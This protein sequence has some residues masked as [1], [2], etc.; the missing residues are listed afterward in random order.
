M[1]FAVFIII[2]VLSSYYIFKWQPKQQTK[3]PKQVSTRFQ[4]L[5][6]DAYDAIRTNKFLKAERA[7]LTILRFDEKNAG[8]YNRLGILYAKQKNY[9]DAIECFEIARS[10]E[11]SPS[12]L[13]NLGL[14][15][16]ETEDYHKSSEAFEAALHMEDTVA[17]RYIAYAKVQEKIDNMKNV[18]HA[19]ER[20]AIIEPS[21]QT[22]TLL[23]DAY[24]RNNQLEQSE[25]IL[26]KI[27]QAK[28]V[29]KKKLAPRMRQQPRRMVM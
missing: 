28:K 21:Q 9:D 18:V 25:T 13:H 19:L 3:N 4:K 6:D 8:A 12:S 7:L 1:T 20:A 11:P 2:L 22:Y 27:A 14:I 26:N 29:K 15:Y 10:I 5:W 16:Y 23:A 17:S 24:Q